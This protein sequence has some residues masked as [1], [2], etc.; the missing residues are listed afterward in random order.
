MDDVIVLITDGQPYGDYLSTSGLKE[1]TKKYAQQLK[2]RKI[3]LLTAGIGPENEK[4][5]FKLFLEGLA[6]SSDYSF[7]AMFDTMDDI[8]GKL[9]KKSC[10]K[11]GKE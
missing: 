6:T 1:T 2:D 4:E 8:L 7:K 5:E 11:P 9:V 3:V 10:I